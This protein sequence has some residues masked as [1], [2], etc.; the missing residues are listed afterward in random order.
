MLVEKTGRTLH[1]RFGMER[2]K[3]HPCIFKGLYV[4]GQNTAGLVRCVA[5][6]GSVGCSVRLISSQARPF[7]N[8]YPFFGPHRHQP[9]LGTVVDSRAGVNAG[10]LLDAATNHKT[11]HD[12]PLLF[13]FCLGKTHNN[14]NCSKNKM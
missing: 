5:S 1:I 10:R 12:P 13:R 7:I 11:R 2:K 6:G 14:F 8:I 9:G 4:R 3:V